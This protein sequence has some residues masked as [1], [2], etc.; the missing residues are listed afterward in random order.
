MVWKREK[1]YFFIN[2]G[3]DVMS[4]P[5]QASTATKKSSVEPVPGTTGDH[6]LSRAGRRR[7]R[8]WVLFLPTAAE[9]PGKEAMTILSP[10]LLSVW[11]TRVQHTDRRAII[12]WL[13]AFPGKS[14][15]L[16]DL[17]WTRG[18]GIWASL[19]AHPLQSL[20]AKDH[21]LKGCHQ[22]HPRHMVCGLSPCRSSFPV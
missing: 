14:V 13:W 4:V 3:G 5:S 12:V 9:V 8:R 7:R 11:P 22:E 18:L 19:S 15:L 20:E 16:F 10:L 21:L 2:W 17:L 1:T 6:S